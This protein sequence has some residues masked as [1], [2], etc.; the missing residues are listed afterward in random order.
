M[1][2]NEDVVMTRAGDVA[3]RMAV[4]ADEVAGPAAPD[5]DARGRFP[6]E[7]LAA[8]KAEGL[9]AALVPVEFGGGGATLS[10]VSQGRTRVGA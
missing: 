5:V 10:E 1:A 7:A 9:L 4:I 3:T 8:L 2:I 6:S